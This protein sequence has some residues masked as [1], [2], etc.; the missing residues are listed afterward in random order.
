MNDKD[1]KKTLTFVLVAGM[2]A[3]VAWEPWR[4][5]PLDTS[6]P[7]SVG[8]KLFPDFSN[9]LAAKSLEIV[10]FNEDTASIRDFKV[11]QTNG[12]WAIPSHS[13]YPADA[14]QHMAEAATALMDIKI[15]G[16]A[17]DRPGDQKE[18]GVITPDPAK[19]K[20][21]MTGVGTRISVK[22]AKD[23][24]LADLVVGKQV[25]NQPGQHY[26]RRADRD[27]I[28][29]VAI[30]TDKL[31]TKFDDWIEKDLLKLAAFDV[32]EVELNDYSSQA[33]IS[34][35]GRPVL[36]I[37]KRNK[38]KVNFDDAKSQWSLAE[39]TGF[40]EKGQPEVVAIAEDEELDSQ[41]LNDLKTAL[42][43][44]Q[45]VDVER[46]PGG[47]SQDLR[48]S[49]E[50]LNNAEAMQSLGERGFIPVATRPGEPR[51]I[52]S[53]EGEATCTT[54]DGVRYVLRFGNLA[55]TSTPEEKPEDGKPPKSAVPNR[56]L[57]VMAQFDE[58]QIP[59][60]ELEKVPGEDDASKPA[61]DKPAEEKPAAEG[62]KQPAA[63]E[64]PAAPPA[65]KK[66]ATTKPAEKPALKRV[67]QTKTAAQETQEAAAPEEKS[68]PADAAETP[69]AGGES[70]P[71]KEAEPAETKPAAEKPA[72][73]GEEEKLA[74]ERE[75]KRKM[76][77]YDAAVKHGQDKVKELNDRFA[78]WYF[79][80]SDDV[81][82]KIHL[83]RND[84][85][86]KK[87][88]AT[89]DD[90]GVLKELQQGIPIGPGAGGL[91]Q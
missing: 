35:Q 72:A 26:V 43:D 20:V 63:P 45:I 58:S 57:F 76:D 81:Y 17:S 48:A 34:A 53:S 19:L 29:T 37:D 60:P 14:N 3:L 31:S 21:G 67:P 91:P 25:K 88:A 32:R 56:Y 89:S 87:E 23:N 42:D 38:I 10:R 90:A 68:P 22:G 55:G 77:D 15:L 61:E 62:D 6:V 33:G 75:N 64:K 84:I 24:V 8:E 40:D 5:A 44:L 7:A 2:A 27:Q 66:P 46:K 52:Y 11:E 59:K 36:E 4:P 65:D 12:L 1:T 74:I 54:K 78:D 50:F 13:N 73:P 16:L 80:I 86:K 82:K 79:I 39:M 9:P 83:G 28:Y 30:T 71:A 85:I 18:Y 69:K 49:D 70:E 51:E 47:L 41:K